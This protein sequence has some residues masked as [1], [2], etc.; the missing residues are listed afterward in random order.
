MA[1]DVS[2]LHDVN[3]I[4]SR[5]TLSSLLRITRVVMDSRYFLIA[6]VPVRRSDVIHQTCGRM[7]RRSDPDQQTVDGLARSA[8]FIHG[9]NTLFRRNSTSLRGR[10]YM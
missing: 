3:Q 8:A 2:R 6:Q 9:D 4:K 7:L 10:A 1:L 5:L